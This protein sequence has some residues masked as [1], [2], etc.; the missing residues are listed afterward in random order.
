MML[1]IVVEAQEQARKGTAIVV[2]FPREEAID[3]PLTK[4]KNGSH[5]FQDRAQ[6]A[7]INNYK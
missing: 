7:K 3:K 2:D 5:V 4:R 6:Y 1:A